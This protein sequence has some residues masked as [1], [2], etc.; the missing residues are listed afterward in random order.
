MNINSSE[1]RSTPPED[2]VDI[3]RPSVWGNPYRVSNS[4]PRTDA[5]RLYRLYLTRN[6]K[7][8]ARLRTLH[9]KTLGCVCKPLPCHGDVLEELSRGAE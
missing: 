4:L 2:R 5:I 8:T 1:W 7:L 3:R 6:K 9:G